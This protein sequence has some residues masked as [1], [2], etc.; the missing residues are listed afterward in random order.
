MKKS[1]KILL[2]LALVSALLVAACALY[3][4]SYYKADTAAIGAFLPEGTALKDLPDGTIVIGPEQAE[5]GFIF[6]PGGKV[7]H[8]AYRP[9]MQQLSEKGVLC[10][11]VEMPFRLAVLNSDAAGD[12]LKK[13]PEIQNWYIGGH[14]LGGAMAANYLSENTDDFKGLVLLGAYSTK[15]LSKTNLKVLSV[16][17]SEDKVLNATKYAKNKKNLPKNFTEIIL[18]GGCHAYFGMYGTQKGDGV[19][20]LSNTDQIIQTAGA[21]LALME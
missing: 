12:H 5:N 14:S 16:Y 19:P 4:G 18:A 1:T 11:L 3:L 10:I 6:Y 20:T 8:T 13:Y 2:V 15:D 17:G 21:I 7:A 9:L